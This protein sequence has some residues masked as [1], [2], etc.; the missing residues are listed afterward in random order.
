MFL[1]DSWNPHL[2]VS[3]LSQLGFLGKSQDRSSS[4][5][6]MDH[7]KHSHIISPCQTLGVQA[8]SS[9]VTFPLPPKSSPSCLTCLH[10]FL[11]S[12][13]I[14]VHRHLTTSRIIYEGP[15]SLK[16]L[17]FRLEVGS[18][19]AHPGIDGG[20]RVRLQHGKSFLQRNLLPNPLFKICST[21]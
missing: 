4:L 16:T 13:D 7:G 2:A 3:F 17:L 20:Q 6:P 8:D 1:V 19:H 11:V 5:L 15:G 14:P 21:L 12:S 18:S 10:G 9:T